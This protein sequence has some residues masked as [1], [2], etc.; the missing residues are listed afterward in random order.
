MDCNLFTGL[1][2]HTL[3]V[4]RIQWLA[5]SDSFNAGMGFFLLFFSGLD[6][7]TSVLPKRVA[8]VQAFLRLP[9]LCRLEESKA[10]FTFLRLLLQNIK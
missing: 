8:A 2:R 9:C 1:F 5:I 10:I 4:I 7:L 3:G 6:F